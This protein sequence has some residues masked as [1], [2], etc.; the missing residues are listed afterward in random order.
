MYVLNR[1]MKQ[2]TGGW[3]AEGFWTTIG[4]AVVVATVAGSVLLYVLCL[5]NA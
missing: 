1:K 5:R 2:V 4:P 3:T